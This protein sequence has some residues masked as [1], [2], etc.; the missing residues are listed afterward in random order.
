MKNNPQAGMFPVT[1]WTLEIIP[2]S[3]GQQGK[4]G[5]IYLSQSLGILSPVEYRP[6]GESWA[7]SDKME[8]FSRN[9]RNL[10]PHRD[11]TKPQ[12]IMLWKTLLSQERPADNSQST[13]TCSK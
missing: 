9:G 10:W 4:L 12:N 2:K 7:P 3:Q 1:L 5:E 11:I 6:Y 8:G 13:C